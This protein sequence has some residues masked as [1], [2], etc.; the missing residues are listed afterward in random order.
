ML[1]LQFIVYD[2]DREFGAE[3]LSFGFWDILQFVLHVLLE[4]RERVAVHGIQSLLY[5]NKSF[6]IILQ[7]FTSIINLVLQNV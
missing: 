6:F 3:T 2:E 1:G 4:L 7:G 5:A